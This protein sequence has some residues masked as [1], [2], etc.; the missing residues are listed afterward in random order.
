MGTEGAALRGCVAAVAAA[1]TVLGA[2]ACQGPGADDGSDRIIYF[3]TGRDVSDNNLYRRLIQEW[4]EDRTDGY[5]AYLVE[6]P[7][8]ADEQYAEM[9]RSAQTGRS[10]YDVLNL[11]NQFTA[12]FAEAGR[13]E[14]LGPLWAGGEGDPA[15]AQSQMEGVFRSEL[16]ETVRYGPDRRIY[17]APFTADVGMLYYRADL[18]DE[19]ELDAREDLPGL[20]E[21]LSE[22][23]G[24]AGVDHPYIGQFDAYE[25]LTVNT[26]E[27]VGGVGGA[28]VVPGEGN[29]PPRVAVID[30]NNPEYGALEFIADGF[31]DGTFHPA[32]LEGGEEDS[33][34]R[35]LGGEA[36]A[37]RNWPTWYRRLLITSAEAGDGEEAEY[38]VRALPGALLGGQSLALADG[39]PHRDRALELIRFL[40]GEDRQKTL[41]YC[42]GYMPTHS[43]VY[44][45]ALP[46]GEAE[47]LCT[48]HGVSGQEEWYAEAGEFL[49]PVG[50]AIADARVRPVTPY[51]SQFSEAVYTGLHPLFTA[52]AAGGEA[53]LD[54]AALAGTRT[55]A[56]AALRGE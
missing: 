28:L 19:E 7:G 26:M 1:A 43:G 37:M 52:A 12:A 15:G 8:S 48:Q 29:A 22:A 32:S 31:A 47:A 50:D 2:A 14:E 10:E 44:T 38:A 27:V 36:V 54:P 34:V 17:A 39:T 33:Y 35:F 45:D 13:I 56:D 20:L 24:E 3:A 25:G 5:R 9:M 49:T 55:E 6:L 11:D 18:L 16:L 21:T 42:G 4:N 46:P 53:P 23:A 51:Y 40:T 30:Q 41:F